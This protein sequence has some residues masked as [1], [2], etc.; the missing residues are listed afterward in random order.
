M[1][2]AGRLK[3]RFPIRSL[4]TF[5][6]TLFFQLHYGPGVDSAFSRNEHQEFSWGVKH[7]LCIKLIT[8]PPYVS[9]L[10]RNYGILNISQ[11]YQL[12]TGIALLYFFFYYLLGCNVMQSGGAHC[13]LLVSYM[14][15]SV[16]AACS[17]K[18]SLHFFQSAQHYTIQDIKWV[19]TI[20]DIIN[21]LFKESVT[22][23]RRE[24]CCSSF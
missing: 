14:N 22:C 5:E 9:Q 15:L 2:E 4:H 12:V 24:V 8:S 1:L 16:K 20:Y 23:C 7:G 10:S 3:V 13:F 18:M 6:F 17:T 11:P 19:P 21:S